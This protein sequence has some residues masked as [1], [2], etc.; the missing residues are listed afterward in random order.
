MSVRIAR[1]PRMLIRSCSMGLLLLAGC[2]DGPFYGIKQTMPWI[3]SQWRADEKL[4]PTDHQRR[5]ELQELAGKL[6]RMPPDEQTRWLQLLEGVVAHDQSPLMRQLAVRTAGA[7]D[8]P[9]AMPVIVAG[10]NDKD[11]IVR[12]AACDVLGQRSEPE[13]I[14]KLAELAG[15]DLDSHVQLAAIRALAHHEGTAVD[16]AMRQALEQND[17]M[18]RLA[19]MEALKAQ[20][21]VDY[22]KDPAAWVAALDG[23]NPP[24]RPSW[25]QRL[26]PWF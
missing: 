3:R 21:G 6:R 5:E 16:D 25:A 18:M 22:G 1:N 8:R 19:A 17:P 24:N 15:G 14:T 12:M 20:R 26:W 13:A 23:K 7:S 2:A 4:G 9:E 10:A 11:S